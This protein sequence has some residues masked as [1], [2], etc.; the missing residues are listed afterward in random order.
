MNR[1]IHKA[2]MKAKEAMSN[3]VHLKV[4]QEKKRLSTVR[5]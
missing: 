1:Y 4:Q 3:E 2:I 5:L